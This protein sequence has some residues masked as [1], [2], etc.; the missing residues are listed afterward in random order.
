MRFT[1]TFFSLLLAST[2]GVFA[3]DTNQMALLI[4]ANQ[5]ALRLAVEGGIDTNNLLVF[6]A[7][8]RPGGRIFID[9][10][11]TRGLTNSMTLTELRAWA[12]NAIQKYNHLPDFKT[13]S[14]TNGDVPKA[15]ET[16]QMSI[17]SCKFSY[18]G[19]TNY[20]WFYCPDKTPPHVGFIRGTSGGI[21]AVSIS[22]YIYGV[23]VG[24]ESFTLKDKSWYDRKLAD[25]IYL[26]HGYN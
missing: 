18:E 14:I 2:L 20:Y 12:T 8:K 21:I 16:L 25:G 11:L 17:P 23:I 22:W 15:V 19:M 7:E 26:W 4:S 1:T 5:L 10:C 13:V 24:P 3:I 6:D 9:E